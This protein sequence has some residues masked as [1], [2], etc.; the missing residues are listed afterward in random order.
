METWEW[1]V[2]AI[3]VAAAVIFV[4]AI[5]S[6]LRKRRRREH[7]QERFGPEYDRTVSSKGRRD[8]E[9]RLSEVEREHDELEIRPLTPAARDRFLDEWREAEARFVSDPRDAT[10]SAERV[11]VRVLE[12]RGYPTD[13]DAEE[14]AA[15]VAVDHP[16]VV[17]RYRHGHAMLE[18]DDDQATE[19]LRKAMIDFRAVF[20]E[21]VVVEPAET[22]R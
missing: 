15:H 22:R 10:R 5:V 2:I 4:G 20:E 19:N 8:A 11:V 17:E 6:A 18:T 16:E 9:R 14:Q 12:D 21:L 13:V 7:L 1:I 3:V